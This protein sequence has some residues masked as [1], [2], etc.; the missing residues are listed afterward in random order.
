[1]FIQ[2]HQ[3]N[4]KSSQI[5]CWICK[6]RRSLQSSFA[7]CRQLLSKWLLCI[8]C[9]DGKIFTSQMFQLYFGFDNIFFRY[10]SSE[11]FLLL[12]HKVTFRYLKALLFTALHPELYWLSLLTKYYKLK[13]CPI[14]SNHVENTKLVS[15]WVIQV[16]I[17]KWV[18]LN[19]LKTL[20]D[21]LIRQ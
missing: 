19:L 7:D 9:L 1:M 6:I 16:R 3:T 11:Y 5:R 20:S 10:A 21:A 15:T 18:Y 4:P 2:A 12:A 17:I 14:N 8:L 13:K